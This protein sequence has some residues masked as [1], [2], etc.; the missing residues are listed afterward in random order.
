MAPPSLTHGYQTA[1]KKISASAIYFQSLPYQVN[2]KTGFIDYD[3]LEE[4]SKLF[5]PN[6]VICGA[7]AYP[8]DWDYK[9]LKAVMPL[10][11]PL[12]FGA[13]N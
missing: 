8:R 5:R 2:M 3:K 13:Q 9:R 6:M 10:P 7:S 11:P 1:K 12:F 4:N